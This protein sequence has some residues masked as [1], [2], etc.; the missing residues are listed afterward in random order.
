MDYLRLA[1]LGVCHS[2]LVERS[3]KFW[4]PRVDD[5]AG[6]LIEVEYRAVLFTRA[7]FLPLMICRI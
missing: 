6:L 7:G 3:E 5:A 2:N 4:W 1:Q